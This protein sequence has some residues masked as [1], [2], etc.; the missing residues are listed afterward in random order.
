MAEEAE[1]TKR[2]LKHL[3]AAA[4]EAAAF[5]APL[6]VQ[7]SSSLSSLSLASSSSSALQSPMPSPANVA[8]T[9]ATQHSSSL[10]NS[11]RGAVEEEGVDPLVEGLFD[12][13]KRKRSTH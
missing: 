6:A 11:P 12:R 7:E 13:L 1:W 9:S 2:R 5:T 3:E 4:A 8:G 10:T